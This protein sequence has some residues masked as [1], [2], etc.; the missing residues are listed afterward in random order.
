M[1]E[2]Q[3]WFLGLLV[4]FQ[5]ESSRTERVRIPVGNEPFFYSSLIGEVLMRPGTTFKISPYLTFS[6]ISDGVD[7]HFRYTYLHHHKDKLID[8]RFATEQNLIPGNLGRVE[9]LSRFRMNLLSFEVVYDAKN[10]RKDWLFEP[11]FIGTYDFP[12]N[13]QKN[14]VK[15]HQLT[16]SV[17][18]HF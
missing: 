3:D 9:E 15:H 11:R 12:I 5:S 8:S 10:A 16:L 6:N 7:L 18:F 1:K 14:A 4:A 2:R 17:A 13:D